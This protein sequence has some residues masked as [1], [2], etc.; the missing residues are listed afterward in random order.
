MTL[1]QTTKPHLYAGIYNIY[2][3]V[4]IYMNMYAYIYIK[5]IHIQHMWNRYNNSL[6]YKY[7][8]YVFNNYINAFPKPTRISNRTD[9]YFFTE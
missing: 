8:F 9:A 4:Y 2:L 1:G 6:K 5:Y 7:C 3:Y